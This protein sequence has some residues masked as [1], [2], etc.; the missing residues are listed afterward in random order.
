MVLV[1]RSWLAAL[2]LGTALCLAA[3]L[4]AWCLDFHLSADGDDANNGLAA[5]ATGGAGPWRTLQR[6]QSQP[7]MPGDRVLLACGQRFQGPVVLV[8]R[9][10]ATAAPVFVGP[11]G[12][13]PPGRAPLI[14]GKVL[15]DAAA[16]AAAADVAMGWRAPARV[17]QLFLGGASLLPARFPAARYL[18]VPVGQAPDK[19]RLLPHAQLAGKALAGA[20]LLARTEE[21]FLEDRQVRNAQGELDTA[22]DYALR[23]GSGFYLTGKPWML[24][25]A[26][27]WAFDESTGLLHLRNPG[28]QAVAVSYDAPL[29]RLQGRGAV[30]VADLALDAAGGDGISVHTDGEVRLERLSVARSAGNGMAVA[31]ARRVVVRDSSVEGAGRDGIFFAEADRVVVQRNLV[32]HA[33]AYLGQRPALA[34]INAHRTNAA[35]VEE[36]LV[37]HSGYIGIRV[38]GDAQVRRNVVEDSCLHLSDCAGIYTWRR[39]AADVRPPSLISGNLVAGVAGD[40]S[41]KLG[42]IDYFTG[43]YLDDYTRRTTVHGN[44]IAGVEQGI[45]LHNAVQNIVTDNQV[46]AARSKH[47]FE[48]VDAQLFK[49]EAGIGNTLSGNTDLGS[50]TRWRLVRP[51]TAD[52]LPAPGLRW[53]VELLRPAGAAAARTAAC[54]PLAAAAAA[55][56]AD[57]LDLPVA[58]LVDCR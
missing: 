40:T 35:T 2:R 48:G 10:P 49:G 56:T 32:S 3:P 55:P 11:A 1:P 33:G 34:A 38:S 27:G 15:L 14:D 19:Q 47:L 54:A 16:S 20:R 36:N 18:L 13:C 6:L 29:L 30:T 9:G 4:Q 7:L 25:A 24:G 52:T 51:G 41:V 5:V 46:V 21:W 42:V 57:P 22:L 50:D 45:Y 31:G 37:R 44:L 26:A 17:A 39:N 58:Q 53:Q 23:P 43:I 12:N 28:G 8:L